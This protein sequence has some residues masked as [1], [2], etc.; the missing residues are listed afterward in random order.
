[1]DQLMPGITG[2][3]ASRQIKRIAPSTKIVILTLD[4]SFNKQGD[5]LCQDVDA[6]VDKANLFTEL[7]P[8]IHKAIGK[9][10]SL[11]GNPE[12]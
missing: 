1:M 6:C 12:R 8:A 3:E 11:Y 9:R 7:I 2:I 4:D 5:S 10:D